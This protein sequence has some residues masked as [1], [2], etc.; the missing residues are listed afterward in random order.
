M[1]FQ[2]PS[3]LHLKGHPANII[4]NAACI[5]RLAFIKWAKI[6]SR[7]RTLLVIQYTSQYCLLDCLNVCCLVFCFSHILLSL[8][9]LLSVSIVVSQFNG[10]PVYCPLSLRDNLR[11]T[12]LNN[13]TLLLL[14][15]VFVM[16]RCRNYSLCEVTFS[17]DGLVKTRHLPE[18]LDNL[19]DRISL[20]SRCGLS[21]NNLLI[22]F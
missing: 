16:H 22:N 11:V 12:L 15:V 5:C 13:P 18:Q 19:A 4:L 6:L 14:A 10:C 17:D 8:V 7:L 9:I 1:P 2:S 3:T 21:W 20:N